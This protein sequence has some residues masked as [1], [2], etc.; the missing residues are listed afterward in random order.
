MIYLITQWITQWNNTVN[1]SIVTGLVSSQHK[2]SL[3]ASEIGEKTQ[4]HH[5]QDW[6]TQKEFL[7]S[8]IWRWHHTPH[9]LTF[10]H[11]HLS[12]HPPHHICTTD[13]AFCS[14]PNDIC[15]IV[16]SDHFSFCLH[17]SLHHIIFI[18]IYI[19]LNASPLTKFQTQN[20]FLI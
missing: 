7:S 2:N 9:T 10:T 1:Y 15:T 19:Y 4:N 12:H 14:L 3:S 13:T 16:P 6:E 18:I 5:C 8:G 20:S 11:T 17:S